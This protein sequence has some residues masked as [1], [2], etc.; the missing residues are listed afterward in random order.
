MI[1]DS[2]KYKKSS[3]SLFFEKKVKEARSSKGKGKLIQVNP[4]NVW[5]SIESGSEL[6]SMGIN[7]QPI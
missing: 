2:D 1:N 6:D 7:I 3:Y 5:E 4:E